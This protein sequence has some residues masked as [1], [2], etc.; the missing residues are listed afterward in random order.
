MKN[1]SW[2]IPVTII[3]INALSIAA[4]WS[5]MPEILPAHFDLEGNA[6]GTMPRTQLLLFPLIAAAVCLAAYFI[7]QKKQKLQTGLVILA[8]GICLILLLSTIVTLTSGKV[9]AFM[10][11]EP[12]VL[13]A[14]V[15]GFAVCAV[16]A[17][18][19]NF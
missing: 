15:V 2:I 12:V 19:C 8:S 3:A 5:S 14:A 1:K 13:L 16:K 18:K 4:K 11:A 6:S 9:P 17:R 7:A 10:L